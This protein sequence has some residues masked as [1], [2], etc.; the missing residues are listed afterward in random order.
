[1]GRYATQLARAAARRRL[2]S[3]VGFIAGGCAWCYHQRVL[4]LDTKERLLITQRVFPLMLLMALLIS[5]CDQRS[6][7]ATPKAT[8]VPPVSSNAAWEP[9]QQTINGVE[10]VLVPPGCFM[11]GSNTGPRDQ[12][13]A[14]EV[15]FTTAF[16]LDL[17]EVTNAA[18]GSEG[19]PFPEA[20]R[21][22]TNLTWREAHEFCQRRGARL[23]TEAEWEYAARGPD[24]LLYPWG[25]ELD[26][27]RLVFDR[28]SENRAW[29]VGTYPDGA[30][31]V[32]ALDMSGN[33]WEWVSSLYRPYPYV[34][35]DGREDAANTSDLRAYRGGIYSYQDFGTSSIMRFRNVPD[36]RD[37][38]IGFRCAKDAG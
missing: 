18:Y 19:S 37:W 36:T 28:N 3:P 2:D 32:G 9:L 4:V 20:D 38:F 33:V 17:T 29:A 16:W 11:M 15:C 26:D 25:N 21:P 27:S 6:N 14:H 30:A 8:P 24:A 10:M 13:P 12:R 31:W 1:M 22:H 34:A 7:P 5:A 35:N 23:P